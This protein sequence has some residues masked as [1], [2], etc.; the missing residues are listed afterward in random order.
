MTSDATKMRGSVARVWNRKLSTLLLSSHA[1]APPT[2]EADRHQHG[3]AFQDHADHVPARRAERHADA[4]LVGPLRDEVGHDPVDADGRDHQA[5][6]AEEDEQGHV[7]AALRQQ[8]V[9]VPFERDDLAGQ[10]LLPVDRPDRGLDRRNAE[11]S[12]RR[13]CG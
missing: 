8:L 3:G 9:H 6:A 11:P 7:E 5:E 13:A 12:D 4:D 2:S 1:A 10:A